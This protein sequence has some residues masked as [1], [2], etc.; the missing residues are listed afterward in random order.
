MPSLVAKV[1]QPVAIVSQNQHVYPISE[2]MPMFQH[3]M[4][5]DN[6]LQPE[7]QDQQQMPSLC[8]S[9]QQDGKLHFQWNS[10]SQLGRKVNWYIF[11]GKSRKQMLEV[12]RNHVNCHNLS[13][14]QVNCHNL[15][16]MQ[17]C[18]L[19]LS[20]HHITK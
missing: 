18:L 4:K 2:L 5:L 7:R 19:V 13:H 3:S 12:L 14:L 16:Y 10:V 6:D 15:S 8:F 9:P 1:D 11:R 20:D 17:L